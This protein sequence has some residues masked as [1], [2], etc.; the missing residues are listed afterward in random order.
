MDARPTVFYAQ[1]DGRAALVRFTAYGLRAPAARLRLYDAGHRLLGTAGML[2]GGE[3]SLRGE[4]WMPL[5]RD[6]TVVSELEAP[7][8]PGI[9]RTTHRLR[10][11]PKWVLHWLRIAEESD[12]LHDMAALPPLNRVIASRIL[13]ADGTLANPLDQAQAAQLTDHVGF[14][15]QGWRAAVLAERFA[16]APSPVAWL[17]DPGA[18]WPTLPLALASSG[19]T[20]VAT[21]WDGSAPL[22]TWVAPDGSRVLLLATAPDAD[23]TSLVFMTSVAAMAGRIERWL[24]ELPEAFGAGNTHLLIVDGGTDDAAVQAKRANVAE[25][26]RRYAFP[27]LVQGNDPSLDAWLTARAPSATTATAPVVAVATADVVAYPAAQLRDEAGKLAESAAR[28]LADLFAAIGPVLGAPETHEAPTVLEQLAARIETEFPGVVVFNPTPLRRT[29]TITL[30]D[31][32]DF[33]VTDVPAMGY[34]FVPRASWTAQAPAMAVAESIE[35]T[36]ATAALTLRVDER[37]GAITSLVTPRSNV[38]WVEPDSDGL[39]A[40]PDTVLE[41]FTRQ[42]VPGVGVELRMRR[43]SPA[44]GLV[45]TMVTVYDALPWIDIANDAEAVGGRA[46]E[47]YFHWPF[48]AGRATWDIPA[49][50]LSAAGPIASL[51]ALSWLRLE[52]PAGDAVL[53]SAAAHRARLMR[54]SVLVSHAPGGRVR[55]RLLVSETG[56]GGEDA[57]RLGYGRQPLVVAPVAGGTGGRLPRFGALFR[58]QPRGVLP[59]GLRLAP[60]GDGA[61]LSLLNV[62]AESQFAAVGAG[63]LAFDGA[64]MVDFLGRDRGEVAGTLSDGVLVSIPARGAAAVR[65]TGLRAA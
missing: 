20:R 1:P 45:R 61:I 44:R 32:S 30:P 23:S 21:R 8:L 7:G 2:A 14:L 41:H 48:G 62:T 6:V 35:H 40:V 46:M 16:I 36:V 42:I 5:E 17:A 9:H 47:Y 58:V 3:T 65:L 50:E 29:D 26:N 37:S 54:P 18:A 15:A 52:W 33:V 55:Y 53:A 63:V 12:V 27:T 24:G 39:N 25:W 4:L 57:W 28:A 56:V 60:D 34:A 31:S 19:I 51:Q 11:A 38:Q 22:R 64:R 43:W 13:A 10:P 49:G 59:I